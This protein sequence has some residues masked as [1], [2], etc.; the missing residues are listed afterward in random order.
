MSVLD[1]CS[2]CRCS[3]KCSIGTWYVLCCVFCCAVLSMCCSV[4][5]CHAL[6][7][8]VMPCR[9][10][11]CHAMLC[12]A[13]FCHALLRSLSRSSKARGRTT[14]TP[15]G[16]GGLAAAVCRAGGPGGLFLKSNNPQPVGWGTIGTYVSEQI[17]TYGLVGR[18]PTAPGALHVRK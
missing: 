8:S 15:V 3:R 16:P 7:C 2:G 9:V 4:M 12:H 11:L 17:R 14:G 5:F 6:F 18:S 1:V 10:M 13:L